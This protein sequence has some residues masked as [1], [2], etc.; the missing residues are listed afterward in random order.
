MSSD[1]SYYVPE[2]SKLP[3]FMAFGLLLLV[4][5]AGSTINVL[6][7]ESNVLSNVSLVTIIGLNK[8]PGRTSTEGLIVME[9]PIKRAYRHHHQLTQLYQGLMY[10]HCCHIAGLSIL[11]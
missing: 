4:L 1:S 2:S 8:P 9:V 11:S 7:N 5:G 6:G 10:L 3:I